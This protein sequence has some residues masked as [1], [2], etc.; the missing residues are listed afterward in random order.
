MELFW[1]IV[2]AII[3]AIVGVQVFQVILGIVAGIAWL[4]GAIVDKAKGKK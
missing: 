3:V 1:F 2:I 4:I